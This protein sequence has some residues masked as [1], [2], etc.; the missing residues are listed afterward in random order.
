MIL[1]QGWSASFLKC[2]TYHALNQDH[3]TIS[4]GVHRFFHPA[5]GA[6]LQLGEIFP[7]FANNY[8]NRN[9]YNKVFPRIN[10]VLV[11]QECAHNLLVS[12]DCEWP[13]TTTSDGVSFINF[14]SW[15]TQWRSSTMFRSR[16]AKNN[17][18]I[19]ELLVCITSREE[20]IFDRWQMSVC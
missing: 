10:N 12:S 16:K 8:S 20:E 7:F 2:R 18:F 17:Q 19:I 5:I 9:N 14:F 4:R 6:L 1:H 15:Q 13:S 3:R 11:M